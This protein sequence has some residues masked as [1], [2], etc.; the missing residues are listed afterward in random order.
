MDLTLRDC[1]S[2]LLSEVVDQ[3][4]VKSCRHS[5]PSENLA[6]TASRDATYTQFRVASHRPQSLAAG[7][8]L[9]GSHCG[10]D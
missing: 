4:D 1:S 9:H 3:A 10:Q 6:L 5:H 7:R 2:P 8:G